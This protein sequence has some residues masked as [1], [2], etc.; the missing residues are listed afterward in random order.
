[1]L[2]VQSVIPILRKSTHLKSMDTSTSSTYDHRFKRIG[3]PVRSAIH[4]LEIGR[5]VVGWV[6]TSEYLLL[7]VFF[8]LFSTFLFLGLM[9]N[10]GG[11]TGDRKADL[12]RAVRAL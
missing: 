3:H 9:A 5:L 4:K 2:E 12:L 10:G 1:V 11:K 6:T 7:Y 8:L